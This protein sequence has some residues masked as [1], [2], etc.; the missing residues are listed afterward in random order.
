M[1]DPNIQS[2]VARRKAMENSGSLLDPLSTVAPAPETKL[3]TDLL[4]PDIKPAYDET[5]SPEY[6]GPTQETINRV[7]LKDLLQKTLKMPDMYERYKNEI[8][9]GQ[10]ISE[11]YPSA[12]VQEIIK[13]PYLAYTQITGEE[14]RPELSFGEAWQHAFKK[15]Q[16]SLNSANV[17]SKINRNAEKLKNKMYRDDQ[18]K[19]VLE[20]EIA[21][22]KKELVNPDEW[23]GGFGD[24]LTKWITGITMDSATFVGTAGISLR[25]TFWDGGDRFN[26]ETWAKDI[27]V[28]TRKM[29]FDPLKGQS[30]SGNFWGTLGFLLRSNPLGSMVS[31]AEGAS[32]Q[33]LKDIG[34]DDGVASFTADA[35]AVL[36]APL[37]FL[38]TGLLAKTAQGALGGELLKKLAQDS[39]TEAI[40]KNI[41]TA[42]PLR[43]W[44][45]QGL[46]NLETTST[47]KIL[48]ATLREG[49]S[50]GDM[51]LINGGISLVNEISKNFAIEFQNNIV[52]IDAKKRGEAM[53]L[54]GV[55]LEQFINET[56]PLIETQ[57]GDV[58]PTFF[59]AAK[60]GAL[61]QLTMSALAKG[62]H[63]MGRHVWNPISLLGDKLT[64]E[65]SSDIIRGRQAESRLTSEPIDSAKVK[66]AMSNPD[67]IRGY[68]KSDTTIDSGAHLQGIRVTTGREVVPEPK[69]VPAISAIEKISESA[70]QPVAAMFTK[71]VRSSDDEAL[72]TNWNTESISK[73]EKSTGNKFSDLAALASDIRNGIITPETVAVATKFGIQ[74]ESE[75]VSSVSV[76]PGKYAKATFDDMKDQHTT[77]Q[78]YKNAGYDGVYIGD[79]L[80][81]LNPEKIVVTEHMKPK[82]A[83][84]ISKQIYDSKNGLDG[85]YTYTDGNGNQVVHNV[86]ETSTTLAGKTYSKME[87]S[88]D[89]SMYNADKIV[90]DLIDN[91]P[92]VTI[93]PQGKNL[94]DAMERRNPRAPEIKDRIGMLDEQIAKTEQQM[95]S[96]DPVKAS[97]LK[98]Q[99]DIYRERKAI[100]EHELYTPDKSWSDRPIEQ[101][102]KEELQSKIEDVMATRKESMTDDSLRSQ[103]AKAAPLVTESQL[104][105]IMHL[106]NNLEKRAGG[107]RLIDKVMESQGVA[108]D[109]TRFQGLADRAN[110]V[111][112]LTNDASAE[113]VTHEVM[114]FARELLTADELKILVDELGLDVEADGITLTR[115]GEEQFVQHGLNHFKRI[116]YEEANGTPQFKSVWAKIADFIKGIYKVISD[117]ISDKARKV[118]DDLISG[119]EKLDEPAQSAAEAIVNGDLLTPEQVKT[120]EINQPRVADLIRQ[121]EAEAKKY[122]ALEWEKSQL[123]KEEPSQT[124]EIY[125]SLPPEERTMTNR[126]SLL[127]NGAAL[128][129]DLANAKEGSVLFSI[130]L[131]GLKWVNDNLDHVAGDKLLE[132]WGKVLKLSLDGGRVDKAKAYHKSGDEYFILADNLEVGVEVISLAEDFAD[133]LA[134]TELNF[135]LEDGTKV[136]YNKPTFSVGTSMM[137]DMRLAERRL[138]DDKRRKSKSG[139]RVGRGELPPGLTVEKVGKLIG[140]D[141]AKSFFNERQLASEARALEAGHN[142]PI[143]ATV[144]ADL[145]SR[146]RSELQAGSKTMESG[147]PD[148][149]DG[150]KSGELDGQGGDIGLFSKRI[151]DEHEKIVRD[152]IEKGKYVPDSVVESFLDKPWAQEEW[153]KRHPVENQEIEAW[154]KSFKNAQDFADSFENPLFDGDIPVIPETI[155]GESVRDALVNYWEDLNSSSSERSKANTEFLKKLATDDGLREFLT[156]IAEGKESISGNG[157]PGAVWA[158]VATF[159][160]NGEITDKS[161]KAIRTFAKNY[162]L[163]MRRAMIDATGDVSLKHAFERENQWTQVKA[164]MDIV[165]GE[166]DSAELAR[167]A[168][169]AARIAKRESK[170][171]AMSLEIAKAKESWSYKASQEKNLEITRLGSELDNVI[172]E[173]IDDFLTKNRRNTKDQYKIKQSDTIQTEAWKV[174]ED[175]NASQAEKIASRRASSDMD[176][177]QQ[178]LRG[179][180]RKVREGSMEAAK[181]VRTFFEEK[182]KEA[183]GEQKEAFTTRVKSYI[184][185]VDALTNALSDARKEHKV[186]LKHLEEARQ[187]RKKMTDLVAK[188]MRPINSKTVHI[189]MW[190]SLTAIQSS[191]DPRFRG[192]RE[193]AKVELAGKE[194]EKLLHYIETDQDLSGIANNPL[195]KGSK[196]VIMRAIE[197]SKKKSLDQMTLA[198]LA[199]LAESFNTLYDAGRDM[200]TL[201][202]N[203]RKAWHEAKVGELME[204]AFKIP[205]NKKRIA[206]GKVITNEVIKQT[207]ST[208][209]DMFIAYTQDPQ[210]V[211]DYLDGGKDFKGKWHETFW[212]TAN[213]AADKELKM[214]V[215]FRNKFEAKL[216]ELGYKSGKTASVTDLYKKMKMENELDLTIQ[217]GMDIYLKWKNEKSKAAL[218]GDGIKSGNRIT[219]EVY[220]QIVDALPENAVKLADWILD[221]YNSPEVKGTLKRFHEDWTNTEFVDEENYTRMRR[222][223]YF[224][225]NDETRLKAELMGR[226]QTIQ[227]GVDKS[228]TIARVEVKEE[229]QTPLKLGIVDEIFESVAISS[230]YMTHAEW[231]RNVRGLIK[232]KDVQTL[233][234]DRLGKA[235]Y[236]VISHWIDKV[237]NPSIEKTNGEIFKGFRKASSNMARA[238]MSYNPK[239]ILRQIPAVLYSMGELTNPMSMVQTMG[240]VMQNPNK[241]FAEIKR[242]SP[243]YTERV[244]P[245]IVMEMF[246]ATEDE[247]IQRFSDQGMRGISWADQIMT[248]I[249]WYAKFIDGKNLGMDEAT[250]AKEA[251][252]AML[253]T[254]Q[255]HRSKDEAYLYGKMDFLRWFTMFTGPLNKAWGQMTY[256]VGAR[257]G[258]GRKFMTAF[259]FMSAGFLGWIMANGR[260]PSDENDWMQI[261]AGEVFGAPVPI[262][263]TSIVNAAYGY[264]KSGHLSPWQGIEELITSVKDSFKAG[265]DIINHKGK[266]ED[267]AGR[268][269]LKTYS[270][271]GLIYGLPTVEVQR[272]FKVIGDGVHGKP[273]DLRDLIGKNWGRKVED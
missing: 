239:T 118:F 112:H 33:A 156:R 114:H 271:I 148:N 116:A 121:L 46:L 214:Q 2:E 167:E 65:M 85:E 182:A 137:K 196:S 107:Q 270:A 146:K 257:K 242:L 162:P 208:P 204:A 73:W 7:Y 77:L 233:I 264:E 47:G 63:G 179:L 9:I 130:D 117:K 174:Q 222:I 126:S 236:E 100:A 123:F 76:L 43:A 230:H 210:R 128:T 220:Q 247:F 240:V 66:E 72:T 262:I 36:S 218:I 256:D 142:D 201:K 103:I 18:E 83:G 26:S 187:Y 195:F 14:L 237:I 141:E 60:Q 241:V 215:E 261:A 17:Q 136:Y 64:T 161:S 252:A 68:V 213:E 78:A 202:K 235:G 49:A 96:A 134:S 70:P 186:T 88:G 11:L 3:T 87:I 56:K 120:I 82:A 265:S 258:F 31:Q 16:A 263:G 115:K 22:W 133:K 38:G 254:Q 216:L 109:G 93:I 255:V 151:K 74:M 244:Q 164:Q 197:N 57:W 135:T 188:I 138:Q 155:N 200:L 50:V 51:A 225:A 80:H 29:G 145:V 205:E 158:A 192:K 23:A 132:F 190:D 55:T 42:G 246:N 207:E 104:D 173:A 53:G 152:A 229:N 25:D 253:R 198:E 249:G 94:R 147:R 243:Q 219:E 153:T 108:E 92:D 149:P 10:A 170:A 260:A 140:G 59:E 34:V 81:V 181:E 248:G 266:W 193:S 166:F 238:F 175:P 172:G 24:G 160:K 119:A 98:K 150:R 61:A 19:M 95:N 69:S 58:V 157:L 75:A 273:V 4:N 48:G 62:V 272:I 189:D 127:P 40:A 131:D 91:N 90:S 71:L 221:Y 180:A 1:S 144:I 28:Q 226:S 54:S 113:V 259:G 206:D 67:A 168:K 101:M 97:E 86:K 6:T 268:I 79:Q 199:D 178:R 191:I 30:I 163:I 203:V 194:M 129:K 250:A 251:D 106:V 111:I 125:D 12:N 176:R 223:G 39:M 124:A 84:E 209:H 224:F 267:N 45:A 27:E 105:S 8:S 177:T 41:A 217:E 245:K 159:S 13:N 20:Q 35:Y 185:K 232:D 165:S 122:D 234:L 228:N 269:A 231:A 154:A 21:N 183:L 184:A 169:E 212:K 89:A 52:R 15:F 32:Y 139:I 102:T 211:F 5:M 110:K 37:N 143:G 99:L 227:P 171:A 44:A